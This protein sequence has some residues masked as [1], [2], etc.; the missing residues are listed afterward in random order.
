MGVLGCEGGVLECPEMGLGSFGTPGVHGYGGVWE[1]WEERRLRA[2]GCDG[3]LTN[4][5]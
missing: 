5:G 3:V 2:T 4:Y 1:A